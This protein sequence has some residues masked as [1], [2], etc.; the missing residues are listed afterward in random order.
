MISAALLTALAMGLTGSLHCAGMCGPIMLVL[1]FRRWEGYRKW[2]AILLY[3]T[4]RITVYALLG[5]FLYSFKSLFDPRWQ[6][7]VAISAGAL[8]LLAGLW[9]FFPRNKISLPWMGI[10]QLHLGRLMNHPTL[11]A[12]LLA[13]MLNGLLPCGL[14]YMALSLSMAAESSLEAIMLMYAFGVGTLPMLLGITI[15]QGR[16]KLF[17]AG[18]I[19]QWVPLILFVFGSLFIVRG[20]NLGIPYLSPKIEISQQHKIKANC[21][22]KLVQ[23]P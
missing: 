2:L 8:L 22:H 12:M 15:M 1:P 7:Y 11:T 19:R 21:C 4:G 14:V 9:S 3:H 13:G 10:V 6:Q 23:L 17:S 20:M 5:W 18:R 16:A